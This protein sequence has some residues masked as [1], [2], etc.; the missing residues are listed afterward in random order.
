MTHQG[1]ADES[2]WWPGQLWAI[3]GYVQCGRK[4]FLETVFELLPESG[5]P[6]CNFDAPK[7]CP[8]DASTSAVTA[9]GLFMLYRLLRPIDPRAAEQ[10]LIESFKL[11]DDL[12]GECRTWKA[13][14]E[15]DEV[16]WGEGGWETIFQHSTINGNELA[17]K[18]L[19][20]HGLLYANFYFIQY[21]NELLKL[22]P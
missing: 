19:L 22:R 7:P 9:C 12:M 2:A 1:Y 17:T 5:I 11:I 13:M 10:Y 18:R 21:G 20:D 8:Y 4:D 6:W 15:G 16:V 3:Y 14:L